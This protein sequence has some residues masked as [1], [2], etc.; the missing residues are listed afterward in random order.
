M[1]NFGCS[2]FNLSFTK[3]ANSDKILYHS[4]ACILSNYIITLFNIAQELFEAIHIDPEIANQML[5]SL[6]KTNVTNLEKLGAENALTGPISRG[7][8]ATVKLHLDKL[9][10]F[11][12]IYNIYCALAEQTIMIA[13]RSGK[14]D[15]KTKNILLEVIHHG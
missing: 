12:Q 6:L 5:L 7:D 13:K 15:E 8:V 9:K 3:I 1:S 10:N 2:L 4:A 14:I 11:P